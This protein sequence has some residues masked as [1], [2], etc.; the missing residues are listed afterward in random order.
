MITIDLA[1]LPS[2]ATTLGVA[3]VATA[4]VISA[5]YSRESG[6]LDGSNFTM[7]LLATLGL[8][9]VA[10]GAQLFLPGLERRATL[11]SWSG[12]FGALGAGLM[13]GVLVNDEDTSLYLGGALVI[14][15]SVAGYLLT[16]GG[17]FVV[18]GILG[19]TVPYAKVFD[20]LVDVGNDEGDNALMLIGAGI[21]VFVLAVT[22]AGWLLPEVRILAAMVAGAGGLFL[23]VFLFA[24]FFLFGFYFFFVS[25]GFL[26]EAEQ[27][28]PYKNDVWM[29]LLY[30][31]ALVLV[32]AGCYLATGFAG[33]RV[34]IT[35]A[36]VLVVPIATYALLIEHPTWWEVVLAAVGAVLLVVAALRSTNATSAGSATTG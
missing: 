16:R 3:L 10:A 24:F 36:P 35:V 18:S 8:L 17:P 33:F 11:I 7:G 14:A 21:L 27:T 4:I 15:I 12:A 23:I 28:N 32:W 2:A 30:C 22:A 34:L 25:D 29:L 31:V 6:D 13:L 20:Q 26:D 19:L 5:A 1:R 9:G